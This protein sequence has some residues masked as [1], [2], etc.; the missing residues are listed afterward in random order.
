MGIEVSTKHIRTTGDLMRF[1]A[2]LKI[3]CLGCGSAKTLGG[4]EAARLS[5]VRPLGDL[6]SKLRCNRCG[7]RDAR[8]TIL[9]PV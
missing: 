8:L 4:N 5:G 6:Q 9:P 1:G 7:Q 3:E 2:G